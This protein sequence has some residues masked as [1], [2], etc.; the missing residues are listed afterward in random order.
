MDTYI[1]RK[2]DTLSKIAQ[3]YGIT[4]EKLLRMNPQIDDPNLIR[5]FVPFLQAA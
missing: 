1:V 2:G 4:L 5:S 3:H